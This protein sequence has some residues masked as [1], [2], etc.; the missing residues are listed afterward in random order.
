M[1]PVDGASLVLVPAGSFVMGSV[2]EAVIG[3]WRRQGWDLR[4]IEA[5]VGGTDFVGELHPHEVELEGF[6]VYER[7]VTIGQYHGFMQATGHLAPV[8]P[9][10]HGPWNSAWR[11]RAPLPGT[12]ALP[13]SSVSWED[14]V[15][16]CRWA[17]AR[18]PTEAEW[19]YAAR[20]PGGLVFPWGDEWEA[21]ACRCADEL[22]RRHFSDHDEWRVW[23][24]GGGSHGPG[25]SYPTAGWLGEHVAQVE[26]PSPPEW[27]P[28]DR[29]WCGVLG[30]AG[31]VREW[32][33]D[34]YDPDYY[35]RSPRRAPRGPDRPARSA[36]RSLRGGSFT[37]PAYT[38]RG[39]QRTFYPPDS[40]DTNNH[41]F[42]CVL[43]AS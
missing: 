39:A 5:T 26:G 40:R 9:R 38:G 7:P 23:L 11:D 24:N 13:V 34:W 33:A 22:A 17:G 19:E 16:Y 3:L 21:G 25:G 42:R 41:G 27:Y 15:A 12:E 10:V 31:Q 35:P 4:W 28:R 1:N 20:G 29:S 43:D 36:E 18:L 32:C 8:D 30:L 37:S 6:W 14:A 2:R